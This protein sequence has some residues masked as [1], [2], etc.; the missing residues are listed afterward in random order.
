MNEG[1]EVLE[2]IK[3]SID[4]NGSDALIMCDCNPYESCGGNNPLCWIQ[5]REE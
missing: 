4:S 5:P 1:F 2:E 3:Y